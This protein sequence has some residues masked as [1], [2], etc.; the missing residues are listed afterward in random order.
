M[1]HLILEVSA[2]IFESDAAIKL[3]LQD[4][5]G[6]LAS[7]LPTKLS[8]CKSRVIRHAEFLIGDGGAKNAF[9]SL[10]IKVFKGREKALLTSIAEEI[11]VILETAF[12]QS[13]DYF[14]LGISVEIT[15]LS[16]IYLN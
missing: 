9:I 12:K 7:R 10:S 15:E 2:N 5:Q 8:S 3:T 13:Q 1:P 11:Y 6:V 14:N 4:C 16:D